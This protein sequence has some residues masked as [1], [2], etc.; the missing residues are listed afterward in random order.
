MH[1]KCHLTKGT[2]ANGSFTLHGFN[3][4]NEVH[5]KKCMLGFF[6]FFYPL[7]LHFIVSF[8]VILKKQ[9]TLHFSSYFFLSN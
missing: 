9:K 3:Y 6:F 1:S 4:L 2:A 8:S 5:S 7:Q